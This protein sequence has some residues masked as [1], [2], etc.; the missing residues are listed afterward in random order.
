MVPQHP[1]IAI[2]DDEQHFRRALTR[3]L[4]AHGYDIFGFDCGEALLADLARRDFDCVLLDLHMPGMTGFDILSKL[5][6]RTAAP[7]V[8]VISAHDEPA[9][10]QRALALDAFEFQAKPVA[11]PALLGALER[12]CAR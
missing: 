12:A 10:V 11:A 6:A 2:L 7:P 4:K 9:N 8:I 1:T 5:Q 3:L